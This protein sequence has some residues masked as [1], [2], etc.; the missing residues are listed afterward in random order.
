[1]LLHIAGLYVVILSNCLCPSLSDP[2]MAQTD[3]ENAHIWIKDLQ[4]VT[5]NLNKEQWGH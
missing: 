4:C 5:Q 1:M 3:A 2:E